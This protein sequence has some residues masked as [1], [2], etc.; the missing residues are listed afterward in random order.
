MRVGRP[1]HPLAP[2]VLDD[3][4]GRLDA[5]AVETVER[6]GRDLPEESLWQMDEQVRI[7]PE[8]YEITSEV[9]RSLGKS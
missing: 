7:Q 3:R 9:A 2:P 6:S 5:V 1:G 4:L 8:D